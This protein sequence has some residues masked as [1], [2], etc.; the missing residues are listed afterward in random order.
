MVQ[1]RTANTQRLIRILQ[2]SQHRRDKSNVVLLSLLLGNDTGYMYT[3][4][5]VFRQHLLSPSSSGIG[6]QLALKLL[7]SHLYLPDVKVDHW[8]RGKTKLAAR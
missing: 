3:A 7:Q 1:N 5:L 4:L 2:R 8:M 6:N